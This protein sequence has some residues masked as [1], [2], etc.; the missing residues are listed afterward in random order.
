M[1]KTDYD[2]LSFPEHGIFWISICQNNA[3]EV[4]TL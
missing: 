1:K 4:L 3:V 2:H